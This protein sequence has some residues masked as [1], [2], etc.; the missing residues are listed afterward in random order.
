MSLL[1][2]ASPWTNGNTE[3]K[4]RPSTM[5]KTIKTRPYMNGMGEPDEYI[6]E[7]PELKEQ[8]PPSVDDLQIYNDNRNNQVSDLINKITSNT[9]IN[10]N[11]NQP[12]NANI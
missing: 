5:R 11:Q 8:L 4:K 7:E 2:S 12:L 3:N 6:N 1:M 9:H 10:I